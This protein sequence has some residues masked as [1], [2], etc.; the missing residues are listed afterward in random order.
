MAESP[1]G[2]AKLVDAFGDVLAREGR[3]ALTIRAYRS[4]L[5]RLAAWL[6]PVPLA[7][8]EGA[9]LAAYLEGRAGTGMKAATYNVRLA[10]IR[11][12]CSW[13]VQ[14]GAR[15]TSPA[16][17]LR[18]RPVLRPPAQG[19]CREA[20]RRV[21]AVLEGN[22]RDSAV[23]LLVLSTGVRLTELVR[24]DRTDFTWD[25]HGSE[26]A[27]RAA[28]E[29]GRVVYPSQQATECMVAYLESRRDTARALFASRYGSR[30]AARTIQGSFA[31][32]FRRAGVTASLRTLRY[33]FVLERLRAGVPPQQL[34][35]LMGYRSLHSLDAFPRVGAVSLREASRLQEERY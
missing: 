2:S 21:L 15:E 28:G 18:P 5:E 14:T 10:A 34:Q 7:R 6:A 31:Q 8:L 29:V 23:F 33:T 9:D 19:L 35:Q 16:A 25:E 12:F 1:A 32:H 4:E 17:D 27:V 24:M 13:L 20:I 22:L 3:A 30:L 26:L 11:R